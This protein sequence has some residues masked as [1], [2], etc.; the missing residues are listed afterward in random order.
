MTFGVFVHR[1]DAI[2][3]D[4]LSKRYQFPNRYLESVK[5]CVGRWIVYYEPTKVKDSKGYFAVARVQRIERDPR[6]NGLY[7]AIIEPGSYLEFAKP[8]AFK[9]NGDWI[10]QGLLNAA[11]KLSGRAR[12][13]VRGL[14]QHD[15]EAILGAG[16]RQEFLPNA[17]SFSS[18]SLQGLSD[19]REE[20]DFQPRQRSEMLQSRLVRDRNFRSLVLDAYDCT[21]A[22]SGLRLL[23]GDG[24]FEV[25]AAHIRPVSQEG[26][27]MLTNG[28]A[29]SRTYHWLFDNGLVA[30][31]P[32]FTIVVSQFCLGLEQ[33]SSSLEGKK[34]CKLPDSRSDWPSLE[35]LG[36]HMQNTFQN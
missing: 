6:N 10:E 29:L 17:T 35:F 4:V 12:S 15:F 16:L 27:D 7:F 20:Y 9:T 34:L 24:T 23:G 8:V 21:C 3:D 14:S 1:R 28:L 18:G 32:E 31:T 11:G 33:L 13:A 30:I 5:K 36:W 19:E 22:I 2:Y 25:E 26:P